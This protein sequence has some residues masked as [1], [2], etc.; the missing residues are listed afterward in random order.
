MTQHECVLAVGGL[1]QLLWSHCD[2][3]F[4]SHEL[5]CVSPAT[6]SPARDRTEAPLTLT[7]PPPA[8]LVTAQKPIQYSEEEVRAAAEMEREAREAAARAAVEAARAAAL[9]AAGGDH[10][11]ALKVGGG[12]SS[13][14]RKVSGLT[15]TSVQWYLS[16]CLPAFKCS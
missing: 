14:S 12:C 9:A 3:G 2:L 11:A 4:A 13:S 6:V 15:P 7:L 10:K 1:C 8:P 16:A 5:E